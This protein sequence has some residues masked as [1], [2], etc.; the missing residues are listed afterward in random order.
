MQSFDAFRASKK[1]K[2][3]ATLPLVG[4]KPLLCEALPNNHAGFEIAW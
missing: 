1:P 3:A 4:V 2:G